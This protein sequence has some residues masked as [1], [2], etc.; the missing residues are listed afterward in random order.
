MGVECN[1]TKYIYK[2]NNQQLMN[3]YYDNV[4]YIS[5]Y[6]DRYL[7]TSEQIELTTLNLFI[8]CLLLNLFMCLFIKT[9]SFKKLPPKHITV[10][11]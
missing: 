10:A 9:E 8:V 3:H 2:Y 6:R 4:I 7:K 5:N 11:Q 1:K